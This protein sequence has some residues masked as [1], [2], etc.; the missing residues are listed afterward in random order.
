[1]DWNT[2]I[3]EGSAIRTETDKKK[4]ELLLNA[5]K[6]KINFVNLIK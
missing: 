3:K 1:M 4:I 5:S 6:R 2:C